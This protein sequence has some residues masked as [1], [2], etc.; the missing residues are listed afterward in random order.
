M[1][2]QWL[3]IK[4]Y[5]RPVATPWLLR[6]LQQQQRFL[7]SFAEVALVFETPLELYGWN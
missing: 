5:L 4:P 2:M 6:E 1:H 7:T 3:V